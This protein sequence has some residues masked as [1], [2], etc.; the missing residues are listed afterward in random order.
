[1]WR[2]ETPA[3]VTVDGDG[4]VHARGDGEGVIVAVLAGREGRATFRVRETG[5][6]AAGDARAGYL[7]DPDPGRVQRRGLPRQVAGAEWV[8]ALAAGLRPRLR[9]RCDHARGARAADLSPGA[10]AELAAPEGDGGG[11]A[12]GRPTARARHSGLRG[13]PALDRRR[14][15]PDP[16]RR[17]GA[18]ADQRHADRADHGPGGDTAAGRDRALRGRLDRGR[19]APGRVPVERECGRRRRARRA[20]Q[21]R[22]DP[23]RGGDLGAVPGHVRRLRGHDPA[24]GRG[25]RHSS[26]RVCRGPTSSTATSGPSS[27]G[28]GS[29][30]RSPPAMPPSSAARRSM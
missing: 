17:R 7:A 8:P 20:G 14:H 21:G 13:R 24:A 22:P 4:V 28:W 5:E 10:R 29:R 18:G 11:A 15:A 1:M 2:S 23:R 3:V 12:R 26:T 27:S 30:R 16:G 6:P 25:F 9:P 19:D